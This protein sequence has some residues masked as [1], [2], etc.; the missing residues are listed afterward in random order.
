MMNAAEAAK[1]LGVSLRYMQSL[2]QDGRVVGARRLGS[3]MWLIPAGEDMKPEIL[4]VKWGRLQKSI[5]EP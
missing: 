4:A 2:C 1:L 3:K 5:P